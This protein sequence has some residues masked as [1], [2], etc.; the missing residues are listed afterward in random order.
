MKLRLSSSAVTQ[1]ASAGRSSQRPF[2]MHVGL[3]DVVM[4]GT[5]ILGI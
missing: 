2:M 4:T 5:K 1:P 3:E